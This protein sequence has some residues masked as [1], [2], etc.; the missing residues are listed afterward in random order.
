MFDGTEPGI[1]P[2]PRYYIGGATYVPGKF[3]FSERFLMSGRTTRGDWLTGRFRIT[4]HYIEDSIHVECT[5]RQFREW[6]NRSHARK[7]APYGWPV[8]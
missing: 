1:T 3:G 2:K 5:P 6:I 7:G 8:Y 4:V